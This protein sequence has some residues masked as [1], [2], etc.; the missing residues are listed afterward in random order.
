MSSK[1]SSKD[2]KADSS[3]FSLYMKHLDKEMY[4]VVLAL[5]F[6]TTEIKNCMQN[7]PKKFAFWC[8]M[9]LSYFSYL[10]FYKIR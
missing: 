3:L 4:P 2:E 5:P 7:E 10:H 6:A 9:G 8:G 1:K